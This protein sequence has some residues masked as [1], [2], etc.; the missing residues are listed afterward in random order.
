MKLYVKLGTHPGQRMIAPGLRRPPQVGE[1][2]EVRE[3]QHG[4]KPQRV[5]LDT[6]RDLGGE[7]LY[8]VTLW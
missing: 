7:F 2:F 5:Q 4:S 6:V 3:V 8:F 1:F